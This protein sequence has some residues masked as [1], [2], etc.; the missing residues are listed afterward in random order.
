MK[1]GRKLWTVVDR[2]LTESISPFGSG[3][4]LRVRATDEPEHRRNLPRGAKAAEILARRRGAGML[5][6]IAGEVTT[7]R[8]GD[9]I[10]RCF[11]IHV[12]RVAIERR[13]LGLTRGT[14]G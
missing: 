5:H 3:V 2:E 7:K 12:E 1:N 8:L 14:R 9:A 4:N 10:T 6:P 11:V 13:N